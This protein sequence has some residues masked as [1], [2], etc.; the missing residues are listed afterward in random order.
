MSSIGTAEE[1]AVWREWETNG[2]FAGDEAMTF[3]TNWKPSNSP[4]GPASIDPAIRRR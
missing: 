4:R 2:K 1:K 3:L